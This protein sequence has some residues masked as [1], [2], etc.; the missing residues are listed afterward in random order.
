[1][2]CLVEVTRPQ[3]V[4]IPSSLRERVAFC[5]ELAYQRRVALDHRDAAQS[6]LG[7]VLVARTAERPDAVARLGCRHGESKARVLAVPPSAESV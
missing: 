2:L 7:L 6:S 5:L 1:M 3:S 4:L